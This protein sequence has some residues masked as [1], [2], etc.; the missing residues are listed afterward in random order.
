MTKWMFW[1][2]VLVTASAVA[3]PAAASSRQEVDTLRLATALSIAREMNPGLR[4][5]VL[6]ADAEAARVP[7]AGAPPDPM[8]S[9]GLMNWAIDGFGPTEPMSMNSIQITQRF[10]WPGKLHFGEERARQLAAAQR[11]DAE[12]VEIGLVAR[13]KAVYFQLAYMDRALGI[14]GSTRQLLREFLGV[15]QTL[16]AVASVPQQ[17]VLQ[18]QVAVAQMTEDIIAMGQNRIAMTARLNALLGRAP[19]ELV[20]AVE[21]PGVRDTLPGL[22][23]LMAMAADKRPALGAAQA[24]VE[25][26]AAGYAASRRAVYPDITVTLGYGQ[27]PDFKDLTTIMFGLSVPLWA[28]SRQLSMRREMLAMQSAEEARERNLYNETFARLAELR[29]EAVRAIDTPSSK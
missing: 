9:F 18:A 17:D 22:D 10:P 3:V 14:M 27:R 13:V 20:A 16:Y 5:A 11:F 23:S 1:A 4:A 28:G 6:R 2:F 24:R 7:Q 12:E 25:A 19:T 21:L 15:A 29:A 26:A 8:L